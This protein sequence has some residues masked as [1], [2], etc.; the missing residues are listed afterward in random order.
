MLGVQRSTMTESAQ[1]YALVLVPSLTLT[2]IP[3]ENGVDKKPDVIMYQLMA[4][5]GAVAAN[6]EKYKV[7]V[8]RF[9][10]GTPQELI[11]AIKALNEIFTQNSVAG[12]NDRMAIIR[13]VFRGEALNLFEAA[14]TDARTRA[15]GTLKNPTLNHVK[16]GLNGVKLGVFPHRALEIQKLW[17]RRKMRKPNEMTFRKMVVAVVRI[18][19]CIPYF[20]GATNLDKFDEAEIIE[21]LEWSI[22]QKWRNKFD[23]EGYIPSLDLR[24]VLLAKCEAIER[25][26]P[27][28]LKPNVHKASSTA[29]T[30]KAKYRKGAKGRKVKV[31][32]PKGTTFC[33][34]HGADKGHNTEQCFTLIN[35]AKKT[36]G[37]KGS[38]S[39]NKF[40]K[41]INLLAKGPKKTK[42]LASFEKVLKAA[43]LKNSKANKAKAKQKPKE[44]TSES[45]SD[46]ETTDDSDVMIIERAQV[47]CAK[48]SKTISSL[49]RR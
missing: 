5:A 34:E 37:T 15:D 4:V 10:T 22:P 7:H 33:T 21:L 1:S 49:R 48:K 19:N 35:R 23:L 16:A 14:L 25:N 38:L 32:K 27:H 11:T 2:E 36:A 18:N 47:A 24:S 39:V 28:A 40:H 9:D 3:V 42:A 46:S 29:S 6:A 41:E 30:T 17:M 43:R 20:P 31:F 45:S 13:S 12:A 26:E 44:P 8:R